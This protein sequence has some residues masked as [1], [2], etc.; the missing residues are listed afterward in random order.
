MDKTGGIFFHAQIWMKPV[1]GQHFLSGML[2]N[3]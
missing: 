2:E 1:E 3:G